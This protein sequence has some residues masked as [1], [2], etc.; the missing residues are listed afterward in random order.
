MP[1]LLGLI[2]HGNVVV[3]FI[4][5]HYKQTT[6]DPFIILNLAKIQGFKR[7]SIAKLWKYETLDLL[8]FTKKPSQGTSTIFDV[9]LRKFAY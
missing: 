5:M 6:I 8:N 1:K 2:N 4:K 9:C 7:E 3:F